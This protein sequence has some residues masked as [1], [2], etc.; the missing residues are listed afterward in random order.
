MISSELSA[1]LKV[2][3]MG[4]IVTLKADLDVVVV[5]VVV[6]VREGGIR[7]EQPLTRSQFRLMLPPSSRAYKQVDWYI[8]F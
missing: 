6:V 5:G 8:L 2:P 7:V 1:G 4:R 3:K